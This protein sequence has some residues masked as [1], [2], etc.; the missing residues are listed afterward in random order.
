M[1][2]YFRSCTCGF[3]ANNTNVNLSD[4]QKHDGSAG[5]CFRFKKR[6][7]DVIVSCRMD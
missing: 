1:A 5:V 7:T 4:K 3:R 2:Y 6:T